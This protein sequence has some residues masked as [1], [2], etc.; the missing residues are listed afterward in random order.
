MRAI[1]LVL[2]VMALGGSLASVVLHAASLF[3]VALIASMGEA[4]IWAF[5][6]I[7]L[8]CMPWIGFMIFDR[9]TRRP[10]MPLGW[11]WNLLLLAVLAYAGINF[12][13]SMR[14]LPRGGGP[15]GIESPQQ[16]AAVIRL[17]SAHWLVFFLFPL[18][19]YLRRAFP[20]TSP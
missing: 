14:G 19:Y 7:G 15:V 1:F 9:A 2:A 11:R 5:Y 4:F 12:Y 20:V 3:G 18:P 13:L 6:G 10:A 16:H 17:A 8:V